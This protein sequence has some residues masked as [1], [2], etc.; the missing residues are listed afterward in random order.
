MNR[1]LILFITFGI[2]IALPSRLL[3]QEDASQ[4]GNLE[5]SYLQSSG[6][7]NSRALILAGKQEQ[8]LGDSKLIGEIKAL[9]GKKDG[10][11]SDKSWMAKLQYD[12]TI[13]ET[14]YA[15]LSGMV[16][17]DPLKG[18][19]LRSTTLAGLGYYFIKTKVDTLKGEAG[20][21]YIHENQV[22]PFPD[23]GYPTA[24]LFGDYSHSF[25][26]KTRFEQTAEFLPNL[27]QG[28][29]YLLKEETAFVTNIMGNLAFKVSYA[30]AYDNLPPPTFTKTDRLFKTALLYTF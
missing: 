8:A 27:K 2:F 29:D 15:F 13:T 5:M 19:E 14:I 4:K 12:Q 7:T 10:I 1:R 9:Y 22:A 17:R 26:D 25:D 28:K 3:A 6:N 23:R 30:I 21:G 20:L 11:T 18:I 24:R 16:E